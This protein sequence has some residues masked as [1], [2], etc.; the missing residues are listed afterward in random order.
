M[1]H[2]VGG[3]LGAHSTAGG[4]WPLGRE[5]PRPRPPPRGRPP[6]PPPLPPARHDVTRSA[7]PARGH[8]SPGA[9]QKVAAARARAAPTSRKPRAFPAAS[10]PRPPGS[11]KGGG[12][13]RPP[14]LPHPA[15][16]LGGGPA[17]PLPAPPP[18]RQ[19]RAAFPPRGRK[20]GGGRGSRAAGG[21][22]GAR[23]GAVEVPDAFSA[24]GCPE[25]LRWGDP[26]GRAQSGGLVPTPH[27]GVAAGRAPS[28]PEV[29]G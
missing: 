19:G 25:G 24:H 9:S 20:G 22:G 15:R 23:S 6:A 4:R 12:P 2:R 27:H 26:R 3:G 17:R 21:P 29:R 28:S 10:A 18:S 14:P 8:L 7:R 5:R 11:G 16:Q 13:G 1:E